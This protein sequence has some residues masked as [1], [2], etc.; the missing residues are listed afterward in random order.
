MDLQLQST[1]LPGEIQNNLESFI[2]EVKREVAPYQGLIFEPED[3]KG[4]KK[5]VADLRKY[6]KDIEDRRKQV[7]KEWLVPYTAFESRVKEALSF[8]DDVITPITEQLSE[9]E[10]RRIKEKTAAIEDLK[11]QVFSDSVVNS[12]RDELWLNDPK[13]INATVSLKKIEEQL[14]VIRLR[15]QND[16]NALNNTDVDLRKRLIE[17]YRKTGSISSTLGLLERIR[18]EEKRAQKIQEELDRKRTER[19]ALKAVPVDPQKAQQKL[20]QSDTPEGEEPQKQEPLLTVRF[21]ATGTRNQ[22]AGLRDY[23]SQQGIIIDRA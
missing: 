22:L 7:K 14:Q 20:V 6:R 16:L 2:E 13:W 10:Q 8:I 18:A 9:A 5:T 11:T 17:E 19:E 12:Y 23:C 1:I 4:A 15:V 21:A 3:T